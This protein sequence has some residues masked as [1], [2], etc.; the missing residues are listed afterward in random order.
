MAS[1][2]QTLSVGLGIL[3]ADLAPLIALR[4]ECQCLEGHEHE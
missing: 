2:L 3:I 1:V 4:L